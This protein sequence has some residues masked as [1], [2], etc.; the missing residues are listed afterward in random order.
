MNRTFAA[1]VGL[2]LIVPFAG[3]Q[4]FQPISY[5]GT[6]SWVPASDQNGVESSVDIAIRYDLYMGEPTRRATGKAT[7][8]DRVQYNGQVYSRR[9]E[10]HRLTVKLGLKTVFYLVFFLLVVVVFFPVASLVETGASPL[11]AAVWSRFGNFLVSRNALGTGVQLT[12][13]L[14][15]SLFYM[16]ISE[17]MGPRVLRNFLTGR[18]HR[19]RQEKRIFQFSDMK[20][21]TAIAERLGSDEYFELLKAYYDTF[22]HPIV[23]HGGEVY[24][25]IGDEIVVSWTPQN[26]LS[27]GAVLNAARAMRQAL[28]DRGT[29]FEARFGVRPSFRAGL[30]MGVVT[31][32]EVGALKKSITFT[33]DVL[34]QT[35]RIQAL[36]KD[37]GQD[38]L[39][40]DA[41]A[42]ALQH[43]GMSLRSMGTHALRGKQEPVELFSPSASSF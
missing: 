29:W 20:D 6:V 5:S 26:G 30:Q 43:N 31:T 4:D 36:C 12:A 13:S 2:C 8:G 38:L 14:V 17:H 1:L 40:G 10:R 15:A 41:V 11:D 23:Q 16:E 33:G 22:S 3:A 19:P 28:E 39:L 18:Y 27:G 21:S 37:L 7:I 42:N 9:L 25:Y 35:A 34:N 32:G 24:Q